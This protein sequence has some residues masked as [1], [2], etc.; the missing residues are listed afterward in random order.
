MTFHY[1]E[2]SL[3]R[4]EEMK[5]IPKMSDTDI[6]FK[7]KLNSTQRQNPVEFVPGIHPMYAF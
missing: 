4:A 5:D 7:P 3:S 6:P 2:F 1:R